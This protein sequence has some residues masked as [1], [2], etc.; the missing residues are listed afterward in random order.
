MVTIYTGHE[1]HHVHRRTHSHM[2]IHTHTHTHL[3]SHTT[4]MNSSA[5]VVVVLFVH[6]P[7]KTIKI[8]QVI[9]LQVTF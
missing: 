5:M 4:Q 3:P 6:L 1:Y 9:S 2:H 7:H 8:S